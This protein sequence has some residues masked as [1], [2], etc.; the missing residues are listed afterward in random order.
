MLR[1]LQ[2]AGTHS[3]LSAFPPFVLV[4]VLVLVLVFVFSFLSNPHRLLSVPSLPAKST[5]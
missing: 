1:E 4:L 2:V 5:P 3:N